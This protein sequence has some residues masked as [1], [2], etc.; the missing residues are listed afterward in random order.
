MRSKLLIFV[1]LINIAAIVLSSYA[2][3]YNGAN[4]AT[5]NNQIYIPVISKS[6]SP[7]ENSWPM[8]G[9]NPERTSWTP[10][11]VKGKLQPIWYRPIEPYIPQ[12]VQVIA[13]YDNLYISTARGLYALDAE[14][15]NTKWTYP[16]E[17]PL[18]NSPTIDNGV[19]YVGGLDH[20]LYAINAYKGEILWSFEADA[21]FDTNPLVIDGKVF[22]GNRDGNF[23][24][25][26]MEGQNSGQ[27]AWKYQTQGPIHFSAAYK[28]G[29]IFF[30]SDDN[31]AY[32]LNAKSGVLVWKSA[33]LPGAGFHSWWP[34]VYRDTVV[35]VGSSG[36]RNNL[37]PGEGDYI[38]DLDRDYLY[39]NHQTL[40]RNTLVG[41]RGADGWVDATRILQYLEDKPWRRTF[42]VLNRATGAEVTYDLDHDGKQEYAPILWFGTHAGTRYPPVIGSDGILYTSNDYASAPWIPR[43]GVSGWRIGTQ[44]ISTPSSSTQAVDEPIAYSAGGD[45][46]YLN[47]CCDRLAESFSINLSKPGEWNYFSYDLSTRVPGYNEMYR[48]ADIDAV[49]GGV[50][51][52]YG[53]HGDQNPPIP[54]RGKVY[55]HRSNA[56]IAFGVP[57]T[58]PARL[59]TSPTQSAVEI[60]IPADINLLKQKLITEIQKILDAGHLRPGYGISGLFDR[61]AGY[62]ICGDDLMDYWHD[63]SDTLYTLLR[64]LPYLPAD[65][66]SGV[67]TYLQNEFTTY[68]PYLYNNIGWNNGTARESFVLL[69]EVEV[70]R[71]N[72]PPSNWTEFGP[73]GGSFPPQ[74][75]YVLWKYALEFNN[76]KEIF[77]I[78]KD[79]LEAAPSNDVLS[80]MPFVHNSY[81]AGY[82]GYLE[83]EKMAGYPESADVRAELN[84]LLELRANTF[85]KDSPYGQLT[86]VP[87]TMSADCY[88]KTLS[89]SRNFMYLVPELGQ[90][91][92]DNALSKVQQ[93]VDEYNQVAPYWFVSEFEQTYAEGAVQPLYDTYAVFQAKALIL[94]ESPEELVKYLD[95]PAVETGDFFYILNLV[96]TLE[97]GSRRMK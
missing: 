21:G 45:V 19:V 50:N 6:P 53:L 37:E 4:Q 41:P 36:Y 7:P 15:G 95:V 85:T 81:I 52:V 2:L 58:P 68:P 11:E 71:I 43:G 51:G 69:P 57:T 12:K 61:P 40:P 92:H 22:L 39:P 67:R 65:I 84:R 42:F 73:W 20:R 46:I 82:L 29:V 89:I 28:D 96:S 59:P 79:K 83:L 26:Y 5:S 18:G 10:E 17:L 86:C 44:Y 78:S 72:F 60:T 25:I 32:A 91:L 27:L 54:Y 94:Q 93:A 77:D 75:F 23:Y 56:I 38:V 8:A 49:Y 87:S 48:S 64:A 74:T 3:A 62:K 66:Q 33:L 88:C 24:A 76:A 1:T 14:T 90:Y 63:P 70:D 30:A 97:A 35:F 31:H 9:A 16:T 55:M 13:A 47:Q 34:V 80:N